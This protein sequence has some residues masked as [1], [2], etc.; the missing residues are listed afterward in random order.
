MAYFRKL[1][2][3]RNAHWLRSLIGKLQF[4]KLCGL[5]RVS[6]IWRTPILNLLKNPSLKTERKKK[7][8]SLRYVLIDGQLYKKSVD[9]LLLKCLSKHESMLV[10]AEVHEGICGAHQAG[11]KMRWLIWRHGYHWP[12]IE[13]DCNQYAK[14]CKAC[15]IHG[16]I[17]RASAAA[18]YPIVK[19]WPF[20]GWAVD[21]IGKIY[22]P[23]SK[24]HNIHLYLL[25]LIISPSEL[26]PYP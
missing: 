13:K 22:P 9:G 1:S 21:L 10:M 18:L 7:L 16:P 15:Q 17:Q 25:R 19:P 5:T 8:R 2:R 4:L 14:G 12:G 11:V 20:R 23:S 24:Q 26:K 6:Q 3:F